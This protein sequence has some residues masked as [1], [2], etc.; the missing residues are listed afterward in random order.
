MTRLIKKVGVLPRMDLERIP[1]AQETILKYEYDDDYY[2]Y[3][4]YYNF[5]HRVRLSFQVS[6]L[7]GKNILPHFTVIMTQRQQRFV[8]ILLFK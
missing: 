3:N 6:Y 7:Q 8:F 2:Y 1:G 4:H 5:F